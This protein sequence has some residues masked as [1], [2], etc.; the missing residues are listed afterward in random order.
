[1]GRRFFEQLSK[2]L[3]NEFP[4]LQGFSVTNLKYC[5]RFYLFYSQ[6][7][8]IRQQLVD[9]FEER[10]VFQIPWG[11]M[12]V[13]KGKMILLFL[14]QNKTTPSKNNLSSYEN[15]LLTSQN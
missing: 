9:E 11:R 8:L 5:K 13:V 3:K 7:K 4:N 6:I 12:Q 15:I 2:D 1:L 14:F 10:I